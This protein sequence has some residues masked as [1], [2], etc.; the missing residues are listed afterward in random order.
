MR[1][2]LSGFERAMRENELPVR[3]EWSLSSSLSIED[4]IRTIRTLM[5]AE[6]S[7]AAVFICNNLLSLGALLGL[8][9]MGIRCPDD[10]AIV[11]FDDHPWAAVSSP[12]LTVVKQPTYAIGARAAEM[13]LTAISDAGS[14]AASAVFD[15][16]LIVREST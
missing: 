6:E 11:G 15:C 2:R 9:E 10:V 7:P 3:P 1:E 14:P 5:Q 13:L 12:P 16:E 8:K 4:G